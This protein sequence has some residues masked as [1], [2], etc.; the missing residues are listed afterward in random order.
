MYFF[1]APGEG[2]KLSDLCRRQGFDVRIL[3][4]LH[5]TGLYGLHHPRDI[6]IPLINYFN[7]RLFFFLRIDQREQEH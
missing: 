7:Q 2:K 1:S 3:P 5:P 4:N 6:P